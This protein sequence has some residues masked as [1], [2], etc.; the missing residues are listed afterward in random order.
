MVTTIKSWHPKNAKGTIQEWHRDITSVRCYV[1]FDGSRT[2]RFRDSSRG[3]TAGC[4]CQSCHNLWQG[5]IDE[6]S[7]RNFLEFHEEYCEW[8]KRG[9]QRPIIDLTQ[10]HNT[11]TQ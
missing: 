9:E 3:R 1:N 7:A 10:S 4:L 5:F 8:R 11:K 6:R 2:Y